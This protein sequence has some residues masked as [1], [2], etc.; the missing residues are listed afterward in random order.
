MSWN[1]YDVLFQETEYSDYEDFK[2]N[3]EVNYFFADVDND[4]LYVKYIG[5][6]GAVNIRDFDSFKKARDYFLEN[7]LIA[8]FD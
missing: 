6:D 4:I 3:E 8:C 7:G 2:E 1:N 5:K